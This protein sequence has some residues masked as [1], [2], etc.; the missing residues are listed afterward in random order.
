MIYYHFCAEH[1]LEGI[2]KD[3][4][5]MGCIPV[6][7]HQGFRLLPNYQWL[8]TEKSAKKQSWAT[9]ELIRYSRTDYRLEIEIP[10]LFQANVLKPSQIVELIPWESHGIFTEFKG[11]DR[12]RAYKGSIPEEWIKSY[13][14]TT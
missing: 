12:W 13:V 9:S 6:V 4:L 8:T 11:S 14:R 1:M 5:T 10:E 2:L 3:G 7:T